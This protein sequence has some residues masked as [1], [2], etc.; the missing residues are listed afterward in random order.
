MEGMPD[1]SKQF[2]RELRRQN[3]PAERKLWYYL[4][5]RKLGGL[6]F[7]RQHSIGPFIVDFFNDETNTIIELDGDVHFISDEQ[8]KK[9]KIREGWLIEKRYKIIRIN[10]VDLFK[11]TE[12]VLEH[13][14]INMTP[15][16]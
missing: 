13:I 12:Q 10:N 11:N 4:R 16:P 8:I 2:R 14:L 5:N 3:T 1:L 6:K 15:S 9:D 7:R